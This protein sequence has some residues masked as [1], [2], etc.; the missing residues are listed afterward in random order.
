MISDFA[1]LDETVGVEK[2]QYIDIISRYNF[3]RDNRN[4]CLL[5]HQGTVVFNDGYEARKKRVEEN[6]EEAYGD[7][8]SADKVSKNALMNVLEPTAG[9][10]LSLYI[11]IGIQL[12][13]KQDTACK[14]ITVT[15][16]IKDNFTFCFHK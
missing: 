3:I 6:L 8:V 9:S 13:I 1:Y 7:F 4:A 12:P 11:K 2:Q 14:I 15:A 5:D 10:S 16:K